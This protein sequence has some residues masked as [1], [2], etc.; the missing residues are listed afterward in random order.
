VLAKLAQ[1]KG[2]TPL[3]DN[4]GAPI[5]HA[6]QVRAN[7]A[8]WQ[9]YDKLLHGLHALSLMHS[10]LFQFTDDQPKY[11]LVTWTLGTWAYCVRANPESQDVIYIW[12]PA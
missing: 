4:E 7:L 9:R 1:R 11:D 3:Y 6:G 5:P 2:V 12:R 10:G 8:R